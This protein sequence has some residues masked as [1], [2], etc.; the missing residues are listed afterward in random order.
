MP[1][2]KLCNGDRKVI[3][4]VRRNLGIKISESPAIQSLY[5][6]VM[7]SGGAKLSISRQ[8]TYLPFPD[9]F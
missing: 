4:V 7:Q 2:N 9:G 1:R 8:L 3:S 5:I 6:A